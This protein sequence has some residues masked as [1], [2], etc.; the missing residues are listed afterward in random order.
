MMGADLAKWILGEACAQ[1][2]PYDCPYRRRPLGRVSRKRQRMKPGT[3][4]IA[5]GAFGMALSL[6]CT[7]FPMVAPGSVLCIFACGALFGKGYGIWEE[8]SRIKPKRSGSDD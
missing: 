6:L 2:A 5:G 8:C 1:Q 3:Y 7:F 4:M